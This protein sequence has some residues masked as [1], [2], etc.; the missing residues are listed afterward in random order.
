MSVGN[1]VPVN[2]RGDIRLILYIVLATII[3]TLLVPLF[4]D[5]SLGTAVGGGFSFLIITAIVI[6]ALCIPGIKKLKAGAT[7]TSK[8]IGGTVVDVF[9]GY[10]DKYHVNKLGV[11]HDPRYDEW[12]IIEKIG[13]VLQS[14]EKVYIWGPPGYLKKPLKDTPSNQWHLPYIDDRSDFEKNFGC[15]FIG[16][17]PFVH[18]HTW[19]YADDAKHVN[20]NEVRGQITKNP[21]DTNNYPDY[22]VVWISYDEKECLITRTVKSQY[23]PLFINT[24]IASPNLESGPA[25][26]SAATNTTVPAPPNTPKPTRA[27]Q[28]FNIVVFTAGEVTVVNPAQLILRGGNVKQ[29]ILNAV[30]TTIRR[31]VAEVSLDFLQSEDHN[32]NTSEFRK[33]LLRLSDG[34][35]DPATGTVLVESARK[36]YGLAFEFGYKFKDLAAGDINT[37]TLFKA[38]QSIELADIEIE[39]L[40]R[41]GTARGKEEE[42]YLELVGKAKRAYLD[43]INGAPPDPTQAKIFEELA[44]LKGTII[45]GNGGPNP[46]VTPTINVTQP[47]GSQTPPTPNP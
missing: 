5:V 25:S 12:D 6:V 4:S 19:T 1:T 7:I 3:V 24:E 26:S 30:Q 15:V 37:A 11:N 44:K 40:S 31:F 43:Q 42:K 14:G 35:V 18:L 46:S 28:M 22:K 10:N 36:M 8:T 38:Q 23:L 34:E 45:F 32:S 41:L 13:V 27:G 29:L 21:E 2:A 9:I 17:W 33:H 47:T 16:M 39:R 20:A